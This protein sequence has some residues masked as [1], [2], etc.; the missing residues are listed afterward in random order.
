MALLSSSVDCS[1]KN[2][3]RASATSWSDSI[4]S[5][6]TSRNGR[7]CPVKACILPNSKVIKIIGF[8]VFLLVYDSI[9]NNRYSS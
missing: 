8:L 4:T 7:T 1:T 9:C 2:V 5:L 6:S 3:F